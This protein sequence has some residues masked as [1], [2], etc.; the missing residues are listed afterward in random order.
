MSD[1]KRMSPIIKDGGQSI[2]AEAEMNAGQEEVRAPINSK[3]ETRTAIIAIRSAHAVFE[4]NISKQMD[5]RLAP[6]DQ[7]T[8][9]LREEL[10][11]E[12]QEIKMLVDSTRWEF[13][14]QLADIENLAWRWGGRNAATR[15][16]IG[17]QRP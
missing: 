11:S 5:G 9:S 10:R 12:L 4:E 8:Q 17:L 7:R 15:V 2:K 6:I 13:K 3:Q 1:F 14:M 16:C